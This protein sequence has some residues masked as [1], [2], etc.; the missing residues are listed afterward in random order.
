MQPVIVSGGVMRFKRNSIVDFLYEWAVK[1]G[2]GLN[3]LAMMDFSQEDREQFVQLIGYS[4]SGYSEL[5]YVSNESYNTAVVMAESDKDEK[6]ARIEAL[7]KELKE[8]RLV[9]A[10]FVEQVEQYL[11][12]E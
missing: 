7:E 2:M 3:E 11:P 8:I 9:L 12:R 10:L 6:D 5:S 4:L 1:R